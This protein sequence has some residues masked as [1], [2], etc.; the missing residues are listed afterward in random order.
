MKKLPCNL[1]SVLC[2]LCCVSVNCTADENTMHK[3]LTQKTL[4]YVTQRYAEISNTNEDQQLHLKIKPIDPRIAVPQCPNGFEFD[5]N[6]EDLL[7]SFYSVRISCDLEGWYTYVSARISYTKNMVVTKGAISPDTVLSAANLRIAQVDTN[8]LRHTGFSRIE[9]VAGA[10]MKQR[11]RDGQLVTRRMLCYVCEGDRITIAA[12]VGA[13]EVKTS[14][15]AQQDGT[16]GET[17]EVKNARSNKTILAQV[18]NA[19]EVVVN[20]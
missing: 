4:E 19:Q 6:D 13:M 12:R 3:L 18:K 16:I 9:E 15:I 11:L 5:I 17:I 1:L 7:K 14:G 8:R 20:L 2:F 10:R